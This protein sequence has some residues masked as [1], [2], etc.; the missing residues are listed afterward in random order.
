MCAISGKVQVEDHVFPCHFSVMG[1]R[2]MDILFGL[3]IL[4]RHQCQIDLKKHVLRFGDGT[5][6]PF[7]NEAEYQREME[8]VQNDG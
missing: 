5:E 3:D 1:D 4:R 8:K 6:T 7:I 2:N